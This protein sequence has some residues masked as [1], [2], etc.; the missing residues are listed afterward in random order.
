MKFV[1]KAPIDNTENYAIW[2]ATH[3]ILD[4]VIPALGIY[5]KWYRYS[6]VPL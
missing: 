5:A 1:P 2:R 6:A 4:V 3:P